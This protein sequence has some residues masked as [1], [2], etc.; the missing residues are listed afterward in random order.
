[1]SCNQVPL[2]GSRYLGASVAAEKVDAPAAGPAS[3]R[4]RS[5]QDAVC[6]RLIEPDQPDHVEEPARRRGHGGG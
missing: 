4:Q 5:C 3:H 6:W 2:K 1:M